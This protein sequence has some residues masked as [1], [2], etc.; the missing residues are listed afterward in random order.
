MAEKAAP[1]MRPIF[2]VLNGLMSGIELEKHFR[3]K[4]IEVIPLD[5][6]RGL[7]LDQT[8]LV[9]DEMQNAEYEQIRMLLTRFGKN[10]R[11][12]VSG[13]ATQTDLPHDGTNP[14]LRSMHRLRGIKEISLVYLKRCDIVRHPLIQLIE[15]RMGDADTEHDGDEFVRD[16]QTWYALRCPRCDAKVWY[17][18]GDQNDPTM[19]D[20]EYVR[21]WHCLGVLSTPE[22]DGDKAQLVHEQADVT[23]GVRVP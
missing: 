23:R 3:E 14:L 18:N 20:V 22:Y 16:H 6:M 2:D 5:V 11:V 21:C 15:E 19:A 4:T 10:S 9:A 1:Y 8:V 12:V 7:S 13:D 17:N